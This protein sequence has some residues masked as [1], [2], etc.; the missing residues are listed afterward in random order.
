[1]TPGAISSIATSSV[2]YGPMR[3]YCSLEDVVVDPAA[4]RRLQQRVVQEEQEHAA[5][6]EHPGDLGERGVDRR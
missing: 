4:A 5:G 6:R 2:R 1:M 3:Q